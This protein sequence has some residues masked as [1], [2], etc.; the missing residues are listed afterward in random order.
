MMEYVFIVILSIAFFS[1]FIWFNFLCSKQKKGSSDCVQPYVLK[2]S[3]ECNDAVQAEKM[4]HMLDKT[5]MFEEIQNEGDGCRLQESE[6]LEGKMNVEQKMIFLREKV[7]Q[8]NRISREIET[9]FPEKS[10][11]LDGI[12]VGNIVE[13]MVAFTYGMNLYRQSEKTHDAEVNGIK[14]QI[15]GTQGNRRVLIGEMP[16]HLLVEFLNPDNGEIE[17]I[18]NGPGEFIW[19]YI[20]PISSTKNSISVSKLIELNQQVEDSF[21]LKP[22]L[23]LKMYQLPTETVDKT[24][25]VPAESLAGKTTAHGYTNRNNQTNIGCLNKPGTHPNQKAYSMHCNICGYDYEA[26]GCDIAIRKCPNCQ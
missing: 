5:S 3:S 10:F 22:V 21:K 17:E 12:M 8:M 24:I 14:V 20:T 9:V 13:I 1:V 15:K 7:V 16:E 4:L 26:N 18:Y 2:H 25:R 23:P 6:I 11:K 19:K